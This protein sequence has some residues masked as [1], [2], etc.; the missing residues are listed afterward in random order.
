VWF[1]PPVGVSVVSDVDDTV[2]LTNVPNRED[3][4]R[5]T[6]MR[7]FVA[8]P[9]M[10]E[11]YQGWQQQG[12][13]FHYVS[14]SPWQL[15][16]E[17]ALLFARSGLPGGSFHLRHFDI[18]NK[19]FF[20]YIFTS[21]A[22]AKPRAIKRLLA[23]FPQRRFVLV[24]DS[25]EKDPEI[26][27]GLLRE[28]P[29]QIAHVLI[30]S[31]PGDARAAGGAGELVA[32]EE[33]DELDLEDECEVDAHGEIRCADVPGADQ[34]ASARRGL[35]RW[36]RWRPPP[37]PRRSSKARPSLA[38]AFEGLDGRWTAFADPAALGPAA[39]NLSN[40]APLEDSMQELVLVEVDGS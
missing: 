37:L 33:D 7:D 34:A 36:F 16:P 11:L 8:V 24:G 12:A 3:M 27:A 6:F 22:K 18:R 35:G 20:K 31:V 1:V 2:K 29:A 10:P 38:A 32:S 25:G 19:Q 5:N 23:T 14:S 30:R 39:R 13:A 40:L 15:A 26:Y 17:I 9:G 28:H 21:S 4:I